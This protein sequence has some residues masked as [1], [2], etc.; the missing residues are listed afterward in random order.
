MGVGALL[1]DTVMRRGYAWVLFVSGAEFPPVVCPS[2]DFRYF[3]I[4]SWNI[5]FPF[6]GLLEDPRLGASTGSGS[7]VQDRL[8]SPDGWLVAIWLKNAQLKASG[9]SYR[10]RGVCKA[11]FG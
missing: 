5:I 11:P 9:C 8:V 1:I 7:E 10:T 6:S 2:P 3:N 4:T